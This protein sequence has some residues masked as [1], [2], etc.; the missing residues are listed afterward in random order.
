[1]VF[2]SQLTTYAHLNRLNRRGIRFLTLRRRSRRM[3][4][5]IFSRPASA[6]RRITLPSLTRTFRT[7]RVLDE[8]IH[9]KDYDG[10]VRQITVIDLGHE[11]PTL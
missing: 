11:E 6:W 1:L 8:R 2:D 3:L 5:Q 9:L 7:P 4:G 10:P